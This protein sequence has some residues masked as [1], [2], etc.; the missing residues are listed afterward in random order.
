MNIENE[1]KRL[2]ELKLQIDNDLDEIYSAF[3]NEEL[4]FADVEMYENALLKANELRSMAARYMDEVI[5]LRKKL[6]DVL[7]EREG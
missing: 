1:M 7:E 3:E 4:Y 6:V 2:N 5:I